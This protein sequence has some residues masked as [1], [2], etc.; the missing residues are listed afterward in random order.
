MIAALMREREVFLDEQLEVCSNPGWAKW[1][2][3]WHAHSG[4]VQARHGP[5]KHGPCLARHEHMGCAWAV[6]TAHWPAQPGTI[7]RWPSSPS[8]RRHVIVD[9]RLPETESL[10]RREKQPP[11]TSFSP[12][13]GKAY[14]WRRRQLGA[15]GSRSGGHLHRC[16][17]V[18][19]RAPQHTM[20]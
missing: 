17:Q 3:T 19:Y 8:R 16:R 2:C 20:R 5:R 7:M 11:L 4:L 13:L 10:R 9:A 14:P 1:A 6:A 15:N 18:P 12:S